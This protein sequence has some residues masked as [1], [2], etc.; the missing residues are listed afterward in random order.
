MLNNIR[1]NDVTTGEEVA[2]IPLNMGLESENLFHYNGKLY[3][4]CN[5]RRWTG[6]DIFRFDIVEK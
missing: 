1:V 2:I 3:V 6:C 4:S 5:N